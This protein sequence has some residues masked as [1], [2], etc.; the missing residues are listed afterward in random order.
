MPLSNAVVI[1]AMNQSSFNLH[2]ITPAVALSL[3]AAAMRC[4][5]P[6][7]QRTIADLIRGTLVA[8]LSG[9]AM[10]AFLHDSAASIEVRGAIIGVV[11]FISDEIATSLWRIVLNLFTPKKP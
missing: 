6:G 7:G 2:E 11:A 3:M 1:P 10:A 8:A 5:L 9:V 4:T